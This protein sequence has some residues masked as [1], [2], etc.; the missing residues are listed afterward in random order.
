[1]IV[2]LTPETSVGPVMEIELEFVFK[3]DDTVVNRIN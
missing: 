2:N 3:S 1:M